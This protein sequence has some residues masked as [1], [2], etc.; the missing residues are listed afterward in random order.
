MTL[1]QLLKK[2]SKYIDAYEF[3]EEHTEEE[4]RKNYWIYLKDGYESDWRRN[5]LVR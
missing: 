5:M 1:K 4:N 2:Y 3:D